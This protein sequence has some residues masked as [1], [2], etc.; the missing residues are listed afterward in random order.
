MEGVVFDIQRYAIHDG[1]GV[2]TTVFLKGCP[3]RCW[4]CQNPE[5]ILPNPQ[6]IYFEY[7]CIHCHRC[8]HVCPV[9]TIILKEDDRHHI[10]RS[11]C[12]ECRACM[13]ACPT[14]ALKLIG[15]RISVENLLEELE[16]DV[17]I[18]ESSNG[19][20]TFSGGEPLFQPEF[21]R[22]ILRRCVEINI[23]TCIETSGYASRSVLESIM[24]YIDLFLYDLKLINDSDHRKYTGVS[25]RII[26]E[27][28]KFLVMKGVEVVVRFPV[29]PTI[30]DTNENIASLL[31]FLS[32]LK[33]VEEVD[34]LPFH[35]VEEKYRH[36]GVK[37]KMPI[38]NTPSK[39]R[40]LWIKER[41]E[42]LGFYV[43]I[44]G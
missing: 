43:K 29:V 23:H 32:L 44:G 41:I 16:R 35:D 13:E 24:S 2:R 14:G 25:N 28:L 17:L 10:D 31:E 22:E 27:N 40:L 6:L 8:I 30:T 26:K 5:G 11:K 34:I 4:W 7:K 39:E 42:S 20:V 33:G 19:G 18:Y 37:Y 36:L 21:L 3:L 1:P 9:N 12:L 15:R 38:H